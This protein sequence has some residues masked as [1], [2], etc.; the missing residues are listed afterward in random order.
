MAYD[1]T[2]DVV[3]RCACLDENYEDGWDKYFSD[4]LLPQQ[5]ELSLNEMN[6]GVECPRSVIRHAVA[7]LAISIAM[8]QQP[9]LETKSIVDTDGGH[10]GAR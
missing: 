7:R 4:V 8:V 5:L 2:K 1:P 10:E 3:L 6:E 9:T